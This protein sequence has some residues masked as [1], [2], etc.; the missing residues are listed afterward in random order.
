VYHVLSSAGA[1]VLGAAYFLP[2]FYFTWSLF[3]GRPAG[4]NPWEAKGLEWQTPSPPPR[5]N[6]PHPPVVAQEPY[7]Y[8]PV[9]NPAA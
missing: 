8:H 1:A 7:D 9:G 6:F 4:A 3:R 2:L 5:E